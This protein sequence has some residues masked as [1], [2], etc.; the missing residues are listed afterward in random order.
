[1][2]NKSKTSGFGKF[3]KR[4]KKRERKDPNA[5]K[6]PV[7]SYMYFTGSYR[8]ELRRKHPDWTFAQ[9]GQEVGRKWKA[10]TLE[11]RAPHDERA[12]AD[13]LRWRAE[14]EAYTPP[15]PATMSHSGR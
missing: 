15:D 7:S 11:E 2:P 1:M 6:N 9:L 10:L 14:L 5:P 8:A 4:P 3:L 12:A 13:K